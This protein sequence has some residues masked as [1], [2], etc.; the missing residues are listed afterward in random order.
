MQADTTM[1]RRI[2]E[3][4]DLVAAVDRIP[5]A[6]K[7]RVRHRRPVVLAG[8]PLARKPLG[9]VV[10]IRRF[11]ASPRR[12]NGPLILLHAV[13][14]DRKSLRRLVDGDPDVLRL[15]RRT[16]RHKRDERKDETGQRGLASRAG[17]TENLVHFDHAM[18]E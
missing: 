8:E 14:F 5:A 4:R 17:R 1:R 15:C 3:V 6:E 10:A 12:R 11:I 7:D 18:R 9:P 13:K 2:A 16:Q